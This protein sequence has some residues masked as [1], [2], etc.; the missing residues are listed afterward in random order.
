MADPLDV[1]RTPI[2]PVD[3][4][5]AFASSL[6]ERLRRAIL[7]SAGGAMT[8]TTGEIST[9]K[10]AP[11]APAW[12]P[13]VTPY[14]GVYDGRRALD[15]YVEV[16]EAEQ[17]GEP[18]VMPD[19]SIGH[20]EIGIGD[21][22]VMVAGGAPGAPEV[23]APHVEPAPGI[24]AAY[25]IF[26]AV[27]DVDATIE[28]AL[29]GGASLERPATDEPY[30]RTGVIRDPFGHRWMV[31]TPPAR[32]TRARQ[33]DVGYVTIGVRDAERAKDLFE[34]VL[35]WRFQ[36]GSVDQGWQVADA[37]PDTGLW[38]GRDGDEVGA[39]LCFRVDDIASAVRTIREHGGTADEP[40]AAPYG[41]LVECTDGAGLRFQVWQPAD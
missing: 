1:L 27:P 28:R 41:Q 40:S 9:D 23:M 22:V 32:A 18:Y 39:T 16:F 38:G 13:D 24:L 19:G 10:R 5:P 35:G 29:A 31:H 12:G 2:E 11:S 8:T 15:W 30:G 7:D 34:A 33:G 20:A 17:R 4:D 14:I 6:R 26:V 21:A 36:P 25:S 37:R 3:P